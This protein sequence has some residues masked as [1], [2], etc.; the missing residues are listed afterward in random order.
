MSSTVAVGELLNWV[1]ANGLRLVEVLSR[2]QVAIRHRLADR[3]QQI[4]HC[5]I[6]EPEHIYAELR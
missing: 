5:T 6:A 2:D 1:K 4:I 3:L